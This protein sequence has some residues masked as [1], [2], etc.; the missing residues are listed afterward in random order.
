[1]Q[2]AEW[3]CVTFDFGHRRLTL[4]HVYKGEGDQRRSRA[5]E[6][7]TGTRGGHRDA[8]HLFRIARSAR[9]LLPM[10]PSRCPWGRHEELRRYA[11]DHLSMGMR[12]PRDL[13]YLPQ[14]VRPAAAASELSTHLACA[15]FSRVGSRQHPGARN[16]R[17]DRILV[18]RC[19]RVAPPGR[20]RRRN[21]LWNRPLLAFRNVG[22]A[23]RQ[24]RHSAVR[25]RV[26]G[27]APVPHGPR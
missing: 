9:R 23:A 1:M 3:T 14:P 5:N 8:R 6:S 25:A 24:H 4:S 18:R 17:R 27:C 12:A 21:P 15:R 22:S 19:G 26:I 11:L 2:S 13:R 20:V 7:R 16:P 10:E